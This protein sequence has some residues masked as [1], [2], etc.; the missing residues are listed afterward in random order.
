MTAEQHP[1][2]RLRDQ[3]QAFLSADFARRVVR[4]VQNH[5]Q[6]RRREYMLVAITAGL[7]LVLVALVNWYIGNQIQDRNLALWKVA[8]AQIK[9]LK[10]SL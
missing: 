10:T 6:L 7:C 2:D 5:D 8:E 4:R 9:A 3:A 1:W